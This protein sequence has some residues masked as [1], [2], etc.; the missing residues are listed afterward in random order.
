MKYYGVRFAQNCHPS[1]FWVEYFT[2]SN[3]VT[4]YIKE[5]GE[6]DIKIIRKTFTNSEQARNW[7]HRVLKKL[8]VTL[9]EDYLN[10][11]DGKA[12]DMQ[13]PIIREKHKQSLAS[14]YSQPEISEYKSKVQIEAQNRPEQIAAKQQRM[15]NN[16]ADPKWKQTQRALIKSA[17]NKPEIKEKRCLAQKS[18][19][20]DDEFRTEQIK[21]KNRP[22]V[23]QAQRNA[24]LGTKNPK[25]DLTLF[26]FKHDDG[27]LE[28][29]IKYDFRTKYDIGFYELRKI[30]NGKTTKG[31][32]LVK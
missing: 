3:Y 32:T 7:E 15:Y 16:W 10:K 29:L 22:E 13:D 1:D 31:W 12:I 28:H 8:K 5:H 9:R 20:Q 25:C 11:S 21:L 26:Y 24:K 23:K 6:P 2:S 19:W 27:T 17:V 14:Y 18:L 4:E 30:L